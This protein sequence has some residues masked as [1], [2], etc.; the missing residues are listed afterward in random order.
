LAILEEASDIR[1]RHQPHGADA[2]GL[3]EPQN[4]LPALL[5][6]TLLC[7]ALAEAVHYLINE[8]SEAKIAS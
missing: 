3:T 4:C 7:R 2:R 5:A 1:A 6:K 8:L